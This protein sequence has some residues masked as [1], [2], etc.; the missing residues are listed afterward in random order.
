MLICASFCSKRVD[1]IFCHGYNGRK[2]RGNMKNKNFDTLAV[3]LDMSRNAVMTP[4]A[5]KEYIKVISRMGYNALMLYME[6]T[7]PIEDEPYFGYM[8]GGY[9][10]QELKELDAFAKA[11]GV[12][13]IPA[14]QTL[15][16]LGTLYRW[17]SK[18]DMDTEEILLVGSERTY[19]LIDK[20]FKSLSECF[21][22]RRINIGMDEAN[23]LG[24][25]RYLDENGYEPTEV[26]MKKHL[27]RVVE[28]GRK[29]GY[30]MQMWSDMFF[31]GWSG[32]YYCPKCEIPEEYRKL[33]P[34]GVAPV[35][36]EY[37]H[38]KREFVEGMIYNHKQLSDNIWF[39]GGAYTWLGFTP[40]ND[41]SII[42]T[43]S[44]ID[45][46]ID[47]GIRNLIMT[48]WGN[49]GGECS[50]WSVL[51]TLHYVAE[52]SRGERDEEK[53]KA[54]F[55]R[56]TGVSF[57][58]FMKLDLPDRIAYQE[59]GREELDYSYA[60]RVNFTRNPSK[61]MFYID[62]F[63]DF[64]AN[65]VKR[66]EGKKYEEYRDALREVGKKSRRYG[67]L[68]R[69]LANLSDCMAIR[70]ELGIITREAY[71]NGDKEKLLSLSKNEYP[72]LVSKIRA[73]LKSLREQW[74]RENNPFGF[75]LQEARI[76]GLIERISSC[77]R[78]LR[79]YAMGK[80]KS[81]PELDTEQIPLGTPGVSVEAS[82]Y[83]DSLG[84]AVKKS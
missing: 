43:K 82:C 30:E 72:S 10:K 36:W 62:V 32:R 21:T 19:E 66:G 84:F 7:Y 78:R 11:L 38:W 12:E 46:C 61:Y 33:V 18:F 76:G 39:A 67:Y 3:F 55:K 28:I 35:Y 6:D 81:I 60:S 20:M 40:C 51:P 58:D 64:F 79:D 53:I 44:A 5:L 22:T 54:R 31:R 65:T 24:R 15:G 57:D 59:E 25:G 75:E 27:D 13:L 63:M 50:R 17:R 52:Y 70:Y 1:I 77:G 23:G 74:M 56:I 9:K 45:A 68:F 29:Y 2:R 26:I 4:D 80:I 34:E 8:R 71:K 41:F 37:Y 73:F 14:I 42:N 47:N 83:L 16:H 49:D 48:T 69:N